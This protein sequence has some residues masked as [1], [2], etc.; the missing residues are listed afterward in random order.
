MT[1]LRVA[2]CIACLWP[3][4]SGAVG[5]FEV[6]SPDSSTTIG[7]RL[8]AQ[9]QTGWESDDQGVDQHRQ[10]ALFMR[11]RRIR[12]TLTVSLPEYRAAFKLH[13]SAA[14]GAVELMDF[15]FDAAF[16]QHL[17]LRIGQ[18]KI[19]FTRYR[20]QSFQRLTFVD[21]AIVTRYFGAE[22]QFGLSI[23]NGYEKPPRLGYA[24][25][26]FSGANARAAHTTGLAGV[27]GETV[28]NPSDLAGSGPKA[29]FHPELACHLSLNAN[30][31]DLS[32]DS[33]AGGGGFRYSLASSVTWDLDPTDFEDLAL[34]L[35]QEF[36]LKY[37][38]MAFM[39]VG[40][41]GFTAVDGS[42]RTRKAA[43]GVL[44]QSA[45]RVTDEFEFSLRY[46][47]VEI[48]DAI[49]DF[50]FSRARS[51]IAGTDDETIM[52]QYK[53]AGL[54]LTEHEATAGFNVYL[55]GHSLK[56]QSDVGL[57]LQERRDGDRTDYLLRSQ[58]QLSF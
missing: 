18:Y 27:F 41:V 8:A 52:S 58:V 2:I 37:R 16:K 26:L 35:A 10:T 47:V 46:A 1:A 39:T 25:G 54:V 28:T 33:D 55:Q 30:G 22:R 32:T 51:I 14:P 42:L 40:Y 3:S 43:V 20:I 48:D 38:R 4:L 53:D 12:P 7:L 31:I 5:P 50:S 49:T 15:H 6:S 34:R 19:P 56:L 45:Y 17:Q 11:A 24:F 13:L 36:L 57:A 29:A 23:H 21:W 44:I 9:L